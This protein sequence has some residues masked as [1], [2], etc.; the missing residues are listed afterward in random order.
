MPCVPSAQVLCSVLAKGPTGVC[1]NGS[2]QNRE[3]HGYKR[4]LGA[5]I[6]AV[7]DAVPHGMLVFFPSY[8]AMKS[9]V[10]EWQAWPTQGK[11][12]WKQLE[13][14]KAIFQE[15]RGGNDF[16]RVR[17]RTAENGMTTQCVSGDQCCQKRCVNGRA[18]PRRVVPAG[19]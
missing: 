6:V 5:A 8:A 12:L 17:S 1:L 14:C 15:P 3:S 19:D 7:A 9:I 16:G 11:S 13:L 2:F 4:D 18:A 10:D